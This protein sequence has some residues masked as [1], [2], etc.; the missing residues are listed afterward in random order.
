MLSILEGRPE[1][2]DNPT[3]DNSFLI[4]GAAERCSY[5]G[6]LAKAIKPLRKLAPASNSNKA[7]DYFKLRAIFLEESIISLEK[8]THSP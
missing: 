3:E 6:P 8:V 1:I 5:V 4:R 7:A 2:F